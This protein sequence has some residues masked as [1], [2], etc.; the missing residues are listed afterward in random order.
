MESILL[1]INGKFA[2]KKPLNEN[3]Q[4]IPQYIIEQTNYILQKEE[5][6]DDIVVLAPSD[7]YHSCMMRQLTSKIKLICS[8]ELY[9]HKINNQEIE[10][11]RL[12]LEQIYSI[13][14]K[15]SSRANTT[16]LNP[17]CSISKTP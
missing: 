17:N 1:I 5:N 2:Y 8:R 15:E 11:A 13:S 12:E 6:R 10:K 3:A 16:L 14:G 9:K 4:R 7:S